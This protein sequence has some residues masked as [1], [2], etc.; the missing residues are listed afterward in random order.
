MCS[1][2]AMVQTDFGGIVMCSECRIKRTESS[3]CAVTNCN[4]VQPRIPRITQQMHTTHH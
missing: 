1:M 2:C 3:T 4:N